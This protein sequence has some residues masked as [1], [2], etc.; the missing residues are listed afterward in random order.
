M[1]SRGEEKIAH[2]LSEGHIPFEREYSFKD[3]LSLSNKP[4]RFDFYVNL[5][6]PI[7]IDYDGQ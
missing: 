3:L 4:L 6:N 7:L 1:S 2:L 5:Q